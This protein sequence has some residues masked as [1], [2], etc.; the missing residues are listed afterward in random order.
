ML[1]VAFSSLLAH[2]IVHYFSYICRF[3]SIFL[4]RTPTRPHHSHATCPFYLILYRLEPTVLHFVPTTPDVFS[5]KFL[6]EKLHFQDCPA[7]AGVRPHIGAG[8]SPCWGRKVPILG[9]ERPHVG[10]GKS[11]Y[12]GRNNPEVGPFRGGFAPRRGSLKQIGGDALGPTN[13]LGYWTSL[14]HSSPVFTF[15]LYYGVVV[16]MFDFHRSDRGSNPGRGGKMLK[17]LRL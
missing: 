15:K 17:C 1:E 13:R 16:S 7:F 3:T 8:K 11:T 10:A 12:C 4:V 5:E 9:Q 6:A 14:G 2:F